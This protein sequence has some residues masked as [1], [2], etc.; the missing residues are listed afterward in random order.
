[1]AAVAAQVAGTADRVAVLGSG[2][3]A[4]AV[5]A[6]LQNLPAPPAITVVARRPETISAVGVERRDITFAEEALADFPAVVSATSAKMRLLGDEAVVAALGRRHGRLVLVDMAMP[7][8]F[9]PPADPAISYLDIDDLASMAA[10]RPRGAEADELVRA[11]ADEAHRRFVDH[12]EVGP[13]IGSMMRL[14]DEIARQTVDRFSGR[15]NDPSDRDVV[16][17]VAHSVARAL[18]ARPVT[19]VKAN[20]RAAEAVDA[21]AGAFGVDDE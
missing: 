16:Q 18:L 14:G 7:P 13:V 3:M 5:I 4:S 2:T 1:M 8:D 15:L 9:A 11:A 21:I 6:A 20:G 17:Q 10:R 12:H 19:Y